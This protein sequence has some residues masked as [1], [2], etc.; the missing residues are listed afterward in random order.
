MDRY[1]EEAAIAP[2][3]RRHG[4]QDNDMH[5]ALKHHWDVTPSQDLEVLMFVGPS[6][7]GEPL[8]I[9]VLNDLELPIVIHAMTARPKYLRGKWN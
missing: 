9:G 2:S 8:E 4:I 6:T 7:T 5:H 3:A 1:L